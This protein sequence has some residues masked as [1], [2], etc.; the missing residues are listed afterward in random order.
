MT[1]RSIAVVGG[2]ISGIAAAVALTRHGHHVLLLESE[3]LLGGRTGPSHL[4]ERPIMMGGKNIGRRYS[5]LRALLAELDDGTFEDFGINTSTVASSARSTARGTRLL[6]LDS[7]RPLTS[8]RSLLQMGTPRDLLRLALLARAV[9]RHD[10]ARFLGSPTFRRLAARRDDPALTDY[11]SPRM[12][13][14]LLRLAT[15]RMNGAEP[16]EAYLGTLGTNLGLLTDTFE[17]LDHG[18]A[19]A[20]DR[21]PARLDVQLSSRVTELRP[22]ATGMQ[23]QWTTSSSSHTRD[24]HTRDADG[25]IL[26]LPAHAAAPLLAPH[27]PELGRLL[28]TVRYFPATVA[29]VKYADDVFTSEIR[30]VAMGDG[31]CSNAGAYGTTDRDLVRFTFSGRRG[32]LDSPTRADV[33]SLV[34]SAEANLSDTFGRPLPERLDWTW[35]HWSAAYCAYSRHHARL[36]DQIATESRSLDGRMSLAGDYLLGASLEACCRSGE[37][38]AAALL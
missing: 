32:R 17:Q 37:A 31:P 25:V 9:R 4:G 18:L 15:V 7:S 1:V 34:A 10:D 20:L 2:G 14:S 35:R 27:R 21:V 19:P 23:V 24:V 3:D 22:H 13:S 16:D 8:L 28:S 33:D 26:A 38:A 5:H 11:F 6:P 36:L 30:A 12:T 29:V